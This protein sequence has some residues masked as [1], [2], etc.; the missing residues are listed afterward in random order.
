MIHAKSDSDVTSLDPS[1]PRSPKRP[2]YYVQ[3]PSRD[4]HDGDKSSSMQATPAFNSPMESPSHPSYGRH[5]RTS[6][7]SRF[8]G[9]FRS[10]SGRKVSRKRNEKGWPECDVIEEEGNYDEFYGDKGVARRCQILIA[11][12]G[13][14]LIFS[15]F[16][17]I[18]WGAARPYKARI[19]LKSLTVHN[20]YFGEG[21]DMTGVPTKLLTMN[22]SVRMS[23][24]N[25][26]TF[27]GIHVTSSP[28]ILMY[29]E[30]A[31]AKGQLKKY[32][33]PRKS[34][35]TVSVN[36]QGIKVPLYGAGGSLAVSD[37][38]SEVPMTLVFEVRSKG[39]VVG[40]LVKS[41]HRRRITCSLNI[42]SHKSKPIKFKHDSCMFE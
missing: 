31:V 10:S 2:V 40:K 19:S 42:D 37:N 39:H 14:I 16:C 24:Y 38:D 27:F 35:R 12:L 41:S 13:F 18:L 33:Q 29:S 17:L 5:S 7:A 30:I 26:A 22:C 15:V 1:S 9:N 6:S 8:S 28:I 4:S 25:P 21:S 23:V 3:S 32:Y 36:L 11:L 20:F 34:H